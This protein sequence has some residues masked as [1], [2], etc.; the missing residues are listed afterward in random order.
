[1][2][3]LPGPGEVGDV[4]HAVDAFLEFDER[5]V[6]VRLRTLPLTLGAGRVLARYSSH[7]LVSSWRTPREIF[8]SSLLT[9]ST[10]ASISWPTVSTS[11]GRAMRLV[12]ESSETW[13]RPS[14]PG[15]S[16]HERAV[17]HEVGDLALDLRADGI[18]GFDLVP[19]I[20]RLLLEAEGDALLFLVR[21]RARALRFPGRP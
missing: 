10:T 20:G 15:S 6:A 9:P 2:V 7:G 4:D 8:C 17:R 1:M 19:R 5:A 13:T 11:A 16:S 3:D 14:M 21:C 18:L 12:Q